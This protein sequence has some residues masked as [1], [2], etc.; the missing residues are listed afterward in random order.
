[1]VFFFHRK[2]NIYCL[3]DEKKLKHMK[4]CEP[5]LDGK[6]LKNTRTNFKKVFSELKERLRETVTS[7]HGDIKP[8]L[9]LYYSGHSTADGKERFMFVDQQSLPMKELAGKNYLDDLGKYCSYILCA[10]DCCYGGK[11][12]P[13]PLQATA[14]VEYPA[15]TQSKARTTD[16]YQFSS[17]EL[18][19][20]KHECLIQLCS[21]SP[22]GRSGMHAGHLSTYT[23]VFVEALL[24]G[25]E[26]EK[27]KGFLTAQDIHDYCSKALQNNSQKPYMNLSGHNTKFPVAYQSKPKIRLVDPNGNSHKLELTTIK[28]CD[29]HADLKQELWS[30]CQDSLCKY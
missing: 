3:V 23:K 8:M 16:P 15:S 18:E 19:I 22:N 26:S 30:K 17:D 5:G 13:I 10:F 11:Y 7:N 24:G 9:Y 28:L 20:T 27:A 6:F 1:M 14:S 25:A 21:S 29:R 2:S 4:H 12:A